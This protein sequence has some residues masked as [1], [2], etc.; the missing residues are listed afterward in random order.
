MKIFILIAILIFFI[1]LQSILVVGFGVDLRLCGDCD[2]NGIVNILD[3]VMIQK[4]GAGLIPMP[5]SQDF[6]YCNVNGIL[7]GQQV[8]GATVD[9]LDA[10]EIAK[11]SIG[12]VQ[13]IDCSLKKEIVYVSIDPIAL[14]TGIYKAQ[15]DGTGI[16]DITPHGLSTYA[17]EM[18]FSPKFFGD[19]PNRKIVF[20]Y[21]VSRPYYPS[22]YD[23][24]IGIMDADGSNVRALPITPSIYIESLDGSPDGENIL[25]SWGGFLFFEY[26]LATGV[27]TEVSDFT[28]GH[29]GRYAQYQSHSSP[30][31]SSTCTNCTSLAQIYY[32]RYVP[33]PTFYSQGMSSIYRINSDGNG[34]VQLTAGTPTFVERYPASSPDNSEIVYTRGPDGTP[35]TF[36]FDANIYV[37]DSSGAGQTLMTPTLG[38][39]L[40]PR[41]SSNNELIFTV[42]SGGL[43]SEIFAMDKV[44]GAPSRRI[45]KGST[46]PATDVDVG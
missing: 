23:M 11:Y 31:I 3:A 41:F 39:R 7:G 8:P 13:D 32:D 1:Y 10:L 38:N 16:V 36:Y 22:R 25:Y 45:L 40:Y 12:L 42:Y 34:D 30:F 19:W 6:E 28:Q 33:G 26:N 44:P 21:A 4:I 37:M 5:R 35:R 9:I 18:Y 27:T 15:A 46:N 14:T 29:Y 24:A 17:H 2:N 20:R 43:N